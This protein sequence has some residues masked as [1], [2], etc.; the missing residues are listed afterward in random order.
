MAL[1][2]HWAFFTSA[3]QCWSNCPRWSSCV[4]CWNQLG[5]SWAGMSFAI[6][7]LIVEGTSKLSSSSHLVLVWLMDNQ[8]WPMLSCMFQ[9][10]FCQP[11]PPPTKAVAVPVAACDH[12][13]EHWHDHV[14]KR[15]YERCPVCLE[16]Q[17]IKF[18]GMPRGRICLLPG[19]ICQVGCCY[20]YC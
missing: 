1:V 18:S 10:Q 14:S 9:R 13:V 4:Q 3:Q 8:Q 20:S 17:E 6:M 12:T 7:I 5:Q 19:F 2:P 16:K 11:L 15:S